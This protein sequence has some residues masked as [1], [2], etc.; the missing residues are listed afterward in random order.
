[1]SRLIEAS[2]AVRELPPVKWTEKQFAAAMVRARGVSLR[3]P[4]PQELRNAA[5]VTGGGIFLLTSL[6]LISE[7]RNGKTPGYQENVSTS[8]PTATNTDDGSSFLNTL[9]AHNVVSTELAQTQTVVRGQQTAIAYGMETLTAVPSMTPTPTETAVPP[10]TATPF[11]L[12]TVTATVKVEPAVVA[13][14]TTRS[15]I[16]QVEGMNDVGKDETFSLNASQLQLTNPLNFKKN[17]SELL[18]IR[19]QYAK[20]FDAQVP[21]LQVFADTPKDGIKFGIENPEVNPLQLSTLGLGFSTA[22]VSAAVDAYTASIG[23]DFVKFNDKTHPRLALKNAD[24]NFIGLYA[25]DGDVAR[26]MMF[27]NEFDDV[28]TLFFAQYMGIIQSVNDTENLGMTVDN[29]HAVAEQL[30]ARTMNHWFIPKNGNQPLLTL[31]DGITTPTPVA[32]V[33]AM[34]WLAE[35]CR[36]QDAP[37]TTGGDRNLQTPIAINVQIIGQTNK[38]EYRTINAHS[39]FDV[40]MAVNTQSLAGA[41]KDN[42]LEIVAAAVAPRVVIGD[43]KGYQNIPAATKGYEVAPKNVWPKQLEEYVPIICKPGTIAHPDATPTAT[44]PGSKETPQGTSTPK[45][46]V[47]ST[48]TV[49]KTNTVFPSATPTYVVPTATPTRPDVTNT[50]H[51]TSTPRPTTEIPPTTRVPSPMPTNTHEFTPIPQTS[52]TPGRTPTQIPV[53]FLETMLPNGEKVI[54]KKFPLYSQLRA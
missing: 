30:V 2:K 32:G 27:A 9:S 5:I 12:P 46:E 51:P 53:M 13:V 22:D 50:P 25:K 3:K 24:T 23:R 28:P 36:V 1:M 14:P 54:L 40:L 44:R 8:T 34:K 39:Q 15:P 35:T 10:I 26:S 20:E 52:P 33:D 16:N 18:V 41:T 4:T 48:A 38:T 11:E 43:I 21:V 7:G 45:T 47:T 49:Q 29:M 17:Y 37:D 31:P 6:A 42:L 19:G